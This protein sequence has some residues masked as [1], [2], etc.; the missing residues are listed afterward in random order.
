MFIDHLD[1]FY[2]LYSR[3][4]FAQLEKTAVMGY[5]R[6]WKN[7]DDVFSRLC[8]TQRLTDRQTDGQIA[9]WI[10]SITYRR[11]IKGQNSAI[12]HVNM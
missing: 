9:L 12:F 10:A 4:K 11:A 3:N 8:T 1:V 7:V 5:M 6:Q 2:S